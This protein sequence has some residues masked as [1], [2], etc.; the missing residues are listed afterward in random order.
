MIHTYNVRLAVETELAVNSF[1]QTHPHATVFQSPAYFHFYL[2]QAQFRPVYLISLNDGGEVEAVLLAVVISESTG[3]TKYFSSRCVVH[4]GPLLHNDRPELLNNMLLS[5][6]QAVNRTAIFTQFRNFRS[7][8]AEA[9]AVFENFGY[10]LR[11]RLNLIVPLS[12]EKALQK[13]FSASRRRQLKKAIHAGATVRPATS[14]NQVHELYGML[15]QLYRKKV[16]KPLPP[17]SFFEEFFNM[18]VPAQYGVILLVYAHETMIGGIVSPIT[19]DRT[20]SELYVCGL[21]KSYPE[22]Y[23]SVVATWAAMEHGMKN[24]VNHFDFMGLGKPGIPYG[25]RDFKLRFGG[26]QVNYGRF[27]RRNQ[28]IMYALAEFGYN[29]L[30]A[31][32]KI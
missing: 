10:L 9:T 31:L 14:L 19:P 15:H 22:Y 30:R 6:H 20:I 13:G 23:P 1:I 3:I 25:V 24:G 8:D 16:K 4:G 32:K 7:W 28:K 29:I 5:L 18:M 17:L 27:A 11:D 21:D 12:N 26:T 2:S